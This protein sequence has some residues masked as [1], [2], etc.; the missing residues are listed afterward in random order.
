MRNGFSRITTCISKTEKKNEINFVWMCSF[1]KTSLDIFNWC[2]KK[3]PK[4]N[5]KISSIGWNHFYLQL[6]I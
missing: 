1:E 5:Q 3:H 2:W 4:E 6:N